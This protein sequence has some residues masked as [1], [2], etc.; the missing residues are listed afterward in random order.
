MFAVSV[1]GRV[2]AVRGEIDLATVGRIREVVQ[3]VERPVTVDL[4]G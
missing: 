1:S 4:T 3:G 2:V